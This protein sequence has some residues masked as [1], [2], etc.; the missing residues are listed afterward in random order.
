VR[1]IRGTQNIV[2]DTLSRTFDSSSL[3]D[4]PNQVSCHLALIAFPLSFRE[5]G[6]LQRQDSVLADIIAKL[7]RGDKVDN[8]SLSKG[9]LYCP[10]LKAA[11]KSLWSLPSLPIFTIPL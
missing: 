4:V 11:A 3:P 6:Q 9:T 2:T 7:D 8:Y 1:R 5:H 10:S